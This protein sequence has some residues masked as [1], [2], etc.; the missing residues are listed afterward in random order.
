MTRFERNEKHEAREIRIKLLHIE[1]TR[2]LLHSGEEHVKVPQL[3]GTYMNTINQTNAIYDASAPKILWSWRTSEV[4]DD[5][6]LIDLS[7]KALQRTM[8]K[9]LIAAANAGDIG[10]ILPPTI[11]PETPLQVITIPDTAT[12]NL[13]SLAI[14]PVDVWNRHSV[15]LMHSG[16][17]FGWNNGD[18]QVEALDFDV[19]WGNTDIGIILRLFV[20]PSEVILVID[21]GVEDTIGGLQGANIS[22]GSNYNPYRI[23]SDDE[24]AEAAARAE[25]EGRK[26]PVCVAEEDNVL[27]LKCVDYHAEDRHHSYLDSLK[28]LAEAPVYEDSSPA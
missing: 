5:V 3:S 19:L 2:L 20:T 28:E 21:E 27:W 14:S 12:S 1:Y 7:L 4:R 16:T 10:P 13:R 18:V 15:D 23:Y 17:F 25:A 9:G 8:P 26:G 6:N 11:E 22:S 24:L